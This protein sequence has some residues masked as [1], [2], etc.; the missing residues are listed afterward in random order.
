MRTDGCPLSVLLTI[1]QRDHLVQRSELQVILFDHTQNLVHEPRAGAQAIVKSRVLGL[2]CIPQLQ[3]L[4]LSLVLGHIARR[5]LRLFAVSFFV[6]RLTKLSGV[7][8][9]HVLASELFPGVDP[10]GHTAHRGDADT[11]QLL[12]Y[13]LRNSLLFTRYKKFAAIVCTD[14]HDVTK[15]KDRLTVQEPFTRSATATFK[16]PHALEL[17]KQVSHNPSLRLEF[18]RANP[19][20]QQ[21]RELRNQASH[22]SSLRHATGSCLPGPPGPDCESKLPRMWPRAPSLAPP[23]RC[24]VEAYL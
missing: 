3:V 19:E 12:D 10:Q 23:T 13:I 16:R 20:R 9:R 6:A 15:F 1:F 14:N 2:D 17:L 22:N 4:L 7:H 21:A 11:L 24:V 8:Y 5:S 18:K